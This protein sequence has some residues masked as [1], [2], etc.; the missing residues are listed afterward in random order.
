M[1]RHEPALEFVRVRWR[2]RFANTAASPVE[3]RRADVQQVSSDVSLIPCF[4]D[5]A[6]E[7]RQITGSKH[8][9]LVDM[10]WHIGLR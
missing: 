8:I 5:G 6:N 1:E 4:G 7:R 10:S 3:T 9:V 2:T